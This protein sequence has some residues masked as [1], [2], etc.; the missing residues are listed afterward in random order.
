MDGRT[1]GECVWSDLFIE[2]GAAAVVVRRGRGPRLLYRMRGAA[3][4]S[5]GMSLGTMAVASDTSLAMATSA[6]ESVK[7]RENASARAS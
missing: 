1:T 7:R 3:A 2:R 6:G 4:E 5:M